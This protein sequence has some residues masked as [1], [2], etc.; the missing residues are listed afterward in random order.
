[1]KGNIRNVFLSALK[2]TGVFSKETP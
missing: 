2:N 1:V